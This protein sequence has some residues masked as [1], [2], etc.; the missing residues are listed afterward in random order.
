MQTNTSCEGLFWWMHH[1][2]FGAS[3]L[4]GLAL[5][6]LG[7]FDSLSVVRDGFMCAASLLLRFSALAKFAL[8]KEAQ[9]DIPPHRYAQGM[10]LAKRLFIL[11]LLVGT[12]AST[13]CVL[14]NDWHSFYGSW[15]IVE[16]LLI[17]ASL[18]FYA[19]WKILTR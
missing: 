19:R 1:L 9:N 12:F 16:C 11:S 13:W 15:F 5:V 8:V 14:R 7:F 4:C 2:S 17:L 10:S 6:P 3:V 18:L